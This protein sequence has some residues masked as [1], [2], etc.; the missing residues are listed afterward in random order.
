MPVLG[1]LTHLP[2]IV[3]P[4]HAAGARSLVPHLARAGVAAGADGVIVEVHN[5]PDNAMSDGKQSLTLEGFG[6]LV[7]QLRRVA[8]AVDRSVAVPATFST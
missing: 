6:E 4:S 1:E 7:P 2:V 5:D 3:D 8:E